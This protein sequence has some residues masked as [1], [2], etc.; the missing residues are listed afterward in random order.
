MTERISRDFSDFLCGLLED[1]GC[2]RGKR[3]KGK[4]RRA[5]T[6]AAAPPMATTVD[7][8]AR[9]LGEASAEG[10]KVQSA[11]LRMDPFARAMGWKG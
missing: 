4:K 2:G 11:V 8:A 3:K 7:T 9:S 10:R 6:Y 1:C 5:R